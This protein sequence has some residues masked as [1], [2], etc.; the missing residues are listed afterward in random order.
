M[1]RLDR[2]I[3]PFIARL[4]G[5]RKRAWEHAP[6]G[7]TYVPDAVQIE[8][9]SGAARPVRN[10]KDYYTWQWH[11]QNISA[12]QFE[13]L[14]L[15][16]MLDRDAVSE[17]ELYCWLLPKSIVGLIINKSCGG[18]IVYGLWSTPDIYFTQLAPVYRGWKAQ[19]MDQGRLSYAQLHE[20]CAKGT[21]ER[22]RQAR[23]I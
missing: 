3:E 19:L 22:F 9:K 14:L 16:G 5:M 13:W 11:W 15:F 21:L 7:W 8:D 23:F 17:E 2:K 10:Q 20:E 1:S 4:P 18:S 6:Y 12:R